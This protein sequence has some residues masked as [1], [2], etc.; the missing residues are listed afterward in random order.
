MPVTRHPR[1]PLLCQLSYAPTLFRLTCFPNLSNIVALSSK[2]G[3]VMETARSCQRYL[4]KIA[5]LPRTHPHQFWYSTRGRSIE[6]IRQLLETDGLK[7]D[8]HHVGKPVNDIYCEPTRLADTWILK[9][10]LAS[11]Q[12]EVSKIFRV[13]WESPNDKLLKAAMSAT[14]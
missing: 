14:V 7:L 11:F 5:L 9:H 3:M 8:R 13:G 10:A 12:D 2:S 6:G 4:P 1:R